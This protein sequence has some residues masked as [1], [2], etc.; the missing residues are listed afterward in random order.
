M[1][2]YRTRQ[3]SNV[4]APLAKPVSWSRVC[5]TMRCRRG[6]VSRETVAFISYYASYCTPLCTP[7]CIIKLVRSYDRPDRWD[8]VSLSLIGLRPRHRFLPVLRLLRVPPQAMACAIRHTKFKVRCLQSPGQ[9]RPELESSKLA[10]QPKPGPRPSQGPAVCR[11]APGPQPLVGGCHRAAL[12]HLH[13]RGR[14]SCGRWRKGPERGVEVSGSQRE[15]DGGI[16]SHGCTSGGGCRHSSQDMARG[17]EDLHPRFPQRPPD[18]RQCHS[19]RPVG[20]GPTGRR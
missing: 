15:Q 10:F 16:P 7:Y 3:S 17:S 2:P 14:A 18:S 20:T 12:V 8:K 6:I 1:C 11:P 13:P 19:P 9:T 5:A 4:A